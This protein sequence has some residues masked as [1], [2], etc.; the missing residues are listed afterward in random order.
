MY[1]QADIVKLFHRIPWFLSLDEAQLD[2]LA[3]IAILHE[4]EPGEELFKEGDRHDFLYILLEGQIVLEMEVPTHGQAE[5]YT[6]EALDIIGWSSL[7]PIVRQRTAGA[8]A[9]QHSLLL[10]FQSKLLEQLCEEDHDLGYIIMRRL[11]NVV[12]NRL[13]TTRV[14]LMDMIAHAAPQETGMA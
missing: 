8:R 13:L 10:G 9:T 12:A 11:A 4:M 1:L 7:T 3:E 14:F 2:R 6:A 5:F